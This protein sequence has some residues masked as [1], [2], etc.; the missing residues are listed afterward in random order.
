MHFED[1]LTPT[2]ESFSKDRASTQAQKGVGHSA[3]MLRG[4]R[5]QSR[6]DTCNSSGVK[7][8]PGRMRSSHDFME[9]QS[10]GVR[11]ANAEADGGWR[12]HTAHDTHCRNACTRPKHCNCKGP[13][14]C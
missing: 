13:G 2:S 5:V 10:G 7:T 12:V 11:L 3:P 1:I 8:Q 6:V 14:R 4:G 9:D